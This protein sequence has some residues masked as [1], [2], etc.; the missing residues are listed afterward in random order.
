MEKTKKIILKVLCMFILIILLLVCRE[1]GTFAVSKGDIIVI[2][3]SEC[4]YRGGKVYSIT[5]ATCTSAQKVY[6][7]CNKCGKA[8]V[9]KVGKALGHDF[10]KTKNTLPTCTTGGE[11][12]FECRNCGKTETKKTVAAL[13]HNWET[14]NN[15]KPTCGKAGYIEESCTRCKIK[16]KHTPSP[17]Q[18]PSYAPTGKHNYVN[19]EC[20]GCGAKSGSSST[21][22]TSTHYHTWKDATCEEPKK[23]TSCGTT[24]GNALGHNYNSNGICTRCGEVQ[25]GSGE[26]LNKWNLTGNGLVG[27]KCSCSFNR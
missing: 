18:D 7:S 17:A 6:Y 8:G 15:V 1:K 5:S 27:R 9:T 26:V 19:G 21:G 14:I 16:R 24:S 3:C 4:S 2:T 22:S 12:K 25:S 23:C 20:T 13:G 10:E 11:I